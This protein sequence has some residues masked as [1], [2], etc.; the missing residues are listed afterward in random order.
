[1][2][3]SLVACGKDD[4]DNK[5]GNGPT[6]DA[7]KL[8][9]AV[10]AQLAAANSMKIDVS[11]TLLMES[12]TWGDH[13]DGAVTPSTPTP[14]SSTEPTQSTRKVE[15][16]FTGSMLVVKTATSINAKAEISVNAT[17]DYNGEE[18][19][20]SYTYSF[21]FIDG[22]LYEYNKDANICTILETL[23]EEEAAVVLEALSSIMSVDST[24]AQGAVNKLLEVFIKALN[25]KDGVGGSLTIDVKKTVD[26]IKAFISTLS[27][28]TKASEVLDFVIGIVN[29]DITTAKLI[30][31]LEALTALTVKEALQKIDKWLTD[32]YGTTIQK[33]FDEAIADEAIG[34][35]LEEAFGISAEDLKGIKIYDILDEA[36]LS[37]FVL[38]DLI[39]MYTFGD[40][41]PTH[42]DFFAEIRNM[43]GYTLGEIGDT[44]IGEGAMEDIITDIKE[45][46]SYITVDKLDTTLSV[47]LNANNSINKIIFN[48]NSDV[49]VHNPS[50]HTGKVDSAKTVSNVTVTVHSIGNTSEVIALPEGATKIPSFINDSDFPIYVNDNG[51]YTYIGTFETKLEENSFA[52]TIKTNGIALYHYENVP[53]TYVDGYTVTLPDEYAEKGADGDLVIT[54]DRERC[55]WILDIGKM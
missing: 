2:V 49:T 46:A 21:Y 29:K 38:W 34:A 30:D 14:T 54:F 26:S 12:S 33:I 13:S 32:N 4:D 1:M 25:I 45:I 48:I 23:D 39:S 55:R 36:E 17:S 51:S 11:G 52:A 43:A 37:N 47:E 20:E 16:T 8:S 18:D 44:F 22:V 24:T 40:D 7:G 50:S 5:G 42:A 41:T 35:L 31:E 19:V 6:V 27:T 28:D 53:F 9:S 10:I 3:F 15:A